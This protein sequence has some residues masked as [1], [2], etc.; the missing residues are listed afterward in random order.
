GGVTA[1]RGAARRGATPSPR[2]P[3]RALDAFTIAAGLEGPALLRSLDV[4][5]SADGS[6]FEVVAR[7]RRREER[8]DL[9][10]VNG[11][12]QYVIDHDFVAVPLG[13]R[14]V[15]A[16][17]LTPVASGDPW[18]VGE[19]LLHAVTAKGERAPWDEWL[20]P[21]LDWP[22]RRSA[23]RAEPHPEREDWYYRTLLA[24]RH[25]P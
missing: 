1:G 23:L 11:H 13:G 21:G 25:A 3:P 7:R 6:T 18:A 16:I 4:E 24:A 20:P 8:D 14:T 15:A 10:W 2:P 19:I 9:R 17:R 22:A 5:T 12:P